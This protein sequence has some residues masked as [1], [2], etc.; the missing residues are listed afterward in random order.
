MGSFKRILLS[1]SFLGVTASEIVPRSSFFRPKAAAA[2]AAV[3]S[4]DIVLKIRGGAGPLDPD[5]VAKTFVGFFLVDGAVSFIAK[6]QHRKIYGI[7]SEPAFDDNW[8]L[9]MSGITGTCALLMGLQLFKDMSFEKALGWSTIPYLAQ[10]LYRTLTGKFT[11]L[12]V[13]N[14]SGILLIISQTVTMYANLKGVDWAKNW[15]KFFGLFSLLNAVIFTISPELGAKSWNIVVEN[16]GVRDFS[17]RAFG[18][19][20]AGHAALVAGPLF[21]GWSA[22]E[23]IGWFCAVCAVGFLD[24]VWVAKDVDKIGAAKA[25]LTV[26]SVIMAVTAATTLL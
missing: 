15:S 1:L 7:P 18:T 8:Y 25:P 19:L 4:S 21:M 5:T 6:D 23:S 11:S 26:W 13:S 12:G 3:P 20:L 9:D 17:L 10:L 16:M 14:S 22:M 2:S 24:M